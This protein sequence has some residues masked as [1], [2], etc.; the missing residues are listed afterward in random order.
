M[1]YGM[2]EYAEEEYGT[3]EGTVIRHEKRRLWVGHPYHKYVWRE[4]VVRD[5]G[6]PKRVEQSNLPLVNEGIKKGSRASYGSNIERVE[7]WLV[8][9][10]PSTIRDISAALGA[11]NGSVSYACAVSTKIGH[12][13]LTEKWG[14]V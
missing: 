3:F 4:V 14:V 11:S 13:V 7:Q 2:R 5:I 10:G 9:N 1:D 8:E 12:N 6:R